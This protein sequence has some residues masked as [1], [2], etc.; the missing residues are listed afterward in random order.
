MDF[1]GVPLA[2]GTPDCLSLCVVKS[3]L[4]TPQKEVR[5][6]G[7]SWELRTSR[8]GREETSFLQKGKGPEPSRRAPWG[9][10]WGSGTGRQ[11]ARNGPQLTVNVLPT[12]TE[13]SL[14]VGVVSLILALKPQLSYVGGSRRWTKQGGPLRRG[15]GK[16]TQESRGGVGGTRPAGQTEDPAFSLLTA[17]WSPSGPC[18]VRWRCP[19]EG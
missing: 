2:W 18:W 14:A 12:P 7:G 13:G 11:V 16:R 6:A 9:M 4:A 19:G 10:G 3:I 5:A 17:A 1:G 15:R 8:L